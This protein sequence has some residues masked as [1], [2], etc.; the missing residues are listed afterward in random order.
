MSDAGLSCRRTSF[1]VLDDYGL[2]LNSDIP[3]KVHPLPSLVLFMKYW[4]GT[5][6]VSL[7]SGGSVHVGD[8]VMGERG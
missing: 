5:N 1:P 2:P 8:A 6:D 4:S 3:Y 7:G